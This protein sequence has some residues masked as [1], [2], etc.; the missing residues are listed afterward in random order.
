M[1]WLNYAALKVSGITFTFNCTLISG[2]SIF[3]LSLFFARSNT[4][5]GCYIWI[6]SSSVTLFKQ[7]FWTV[8]PFPK[9][10]M[11]CSNVYYNKLWDYLHCF[12]N[13][14]MTDDL[15]FQLLLFN[16]SLTVMSVTHSN[17]GHI[18]VP[19]IINMILLKLASYR[20]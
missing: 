14:Y 11:H 7:E 6:L 4:E 8:F 16:D 3:F 5:R 13:H 10:A 18:I 17:K 19:F 2:I 20:N 15:Y 12:Q 1:F 9:K